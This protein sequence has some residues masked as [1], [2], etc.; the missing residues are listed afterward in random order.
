MRN[1]L[2][3]TSYDDMGIVDYNEFIRKT[4]GKKVKIQY[5]IH[6]GVDIKD[7]KIISVLESEKLIE[8]IK[9]VSSGFIDMIEEMSSYIIR[10]VYRDEEEDLIVNEWRIL[11]IA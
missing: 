8:I 1:K 6:E 9:N 5:L 7:E 10:A 3:L 4:N 11:D 2:N